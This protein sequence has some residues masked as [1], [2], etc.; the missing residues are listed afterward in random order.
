MRMEV[1]EKKKSKVGMKA[2]I[3]AIVLLPVSQLHCTFW[4]V[5]TMLDRP[6]TTA[7]FPSITTPLRS[8]NSMQPYGGK[9]VCEMKK[10]C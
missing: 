4:Y 6:N 9:N 2:N 7:S 1:K 10:I 5:P 8:N 3:H